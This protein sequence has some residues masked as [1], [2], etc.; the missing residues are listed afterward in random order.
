ML[1]H[2]NDCYC[3][4]IEKGVPNINKRVDCHETIEVHWVLS[5]SGHKTGTGLG[6]AY[7]LMG[8]LETDKN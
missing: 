2:L 6:N 5:A 3:A 7:T 8:N 4:F 1:P